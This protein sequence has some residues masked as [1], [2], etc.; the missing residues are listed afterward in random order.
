MLLMD[1][2]E[3]IQTNEYSMSK[4]TYYLF[5]VVV[6]V[7]GVVAFWTYS[8]ATDGE[9]TICVQKGGTVHVVGEGFK[10]SECNKN[11]TLLSWNIQGPAGPKG[12]KGDKGDP[13]S[14]GEKGDQGDRGEPGTNGT[15][16]H[17]FD[18]NNNDLGNFVGYAGDNILHVYSPGVGGLIT[19][20]ITLSNPRT[21]TIL[22][23]QHIVYL[24]P[25]CAGTPYV[26]HVASAVPLTVLRDG[27][28]S[29]FFIPT[30]DAPVMSQSVSELRS[31]GCGNTDPQELKDYYPLRQVTLPFAYPPAWPLRIVSQ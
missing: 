20:T 12:D 11:E 13:G 23:V 28:T 8:Y 3:R 17:V 21:V 10:Q 15:A 18:A 22:P 1:G 31:Q 9:I 30:T 6:A 27:S 26:G 2:G 16:L 14:P 29:A 25:D 19:F 7:I 4:R 5:G 24:L